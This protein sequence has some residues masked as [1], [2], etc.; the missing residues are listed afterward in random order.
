MRTVK[1][2]EDGPISTTI[3]CAK[4]CLHPSSQRHTPERTFDIF[5][6]ETSSPG[7]VR[8]QVEKTRIL[9]D[10]HGLTKTTFGA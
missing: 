2:L 3:G 7:R 8:P 10:Q 6:S 9:V 4:F 1:T 5:S